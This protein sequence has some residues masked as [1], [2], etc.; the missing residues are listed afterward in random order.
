MKK[1]GG[2]GEESVCERVI[3]TKGAVTK[4]VVHVMKCVNNS[5][6][7]LR[8]I[9]MNG[10]IAETWSHCETG[11]TRMQQQNSCHKVESTTAE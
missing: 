5:L 3:I 6:T 10:C 1:E 4:H 8:N 9:S 7:K 11:E 2:R